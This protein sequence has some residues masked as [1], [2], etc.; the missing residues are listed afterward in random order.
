MHWRR[1]VAGE[2]RGEWLLDDLNQDRCEDFQAPAPSR[3]WSN[4]PAAAPMCVP[5]VWELFAYRHHQELPLL[6]F[7][8]ARPTLTERVWKE[9]RWIMP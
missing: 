6:P 4:L 8:P 2:G 7:R 5:A 3:P 1:K 9:L